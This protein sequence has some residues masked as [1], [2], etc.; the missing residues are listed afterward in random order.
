MSQVIVTITPDGHSTVEA[1][2]V[3]GSGCQALTREIEKALGVNTGDNK[4][5]EFHQQAVA[6]MRR[7]VQQS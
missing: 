5:A 7:E 6:T 3:R 4:T 2:G 1:K